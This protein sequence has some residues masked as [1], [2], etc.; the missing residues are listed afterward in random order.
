[1]TTT[2]HTI[3]SADHRDDAALLAASADDD[4]RAFAVVFERHVG[5]LHA[6]L[7]ARVGASAAE[8]LVAETFAAAWMARDKFWSQATTARPW[9]YGIATHVIRR[10]R[11]REIR[12]NESVVSAQHTL[13]G[14]TV[15]A[16]SEP[17]DGDPAL[18]AALGTLSASERD[19]LM[20][21]ALGEMSIGE[22]A[23]AL[24][25]SSVAARVRLHRA[26]QRLAN[27]LDPT[28]RGAE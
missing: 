16:P 18:M 24:Q 17:G 19:V 26:R 13:D 23:K 21:T 11:E 10:H 20:L 22:V 9:L 2:R 1:M 12:W 5:A 14:P 4:T 25:I 7:A 15:D 27:V 8:D 28:D 6:Y 3:P